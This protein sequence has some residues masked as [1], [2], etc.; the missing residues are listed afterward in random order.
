M[1]GDFAE[2]YSTR[3]NGDLKRL[4]INVVGDSDPSKIKSDEYGYKFSEDAV[5][6]KQ[7]KDCAV[8]VIRY[9]AS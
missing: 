8:K 3:E 5:E 4:D 6:V 7:K 2:K 1:I 9:Q